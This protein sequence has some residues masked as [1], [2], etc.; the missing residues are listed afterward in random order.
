L[1]G[2]EEHVKCELAL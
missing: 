2:F 1:D